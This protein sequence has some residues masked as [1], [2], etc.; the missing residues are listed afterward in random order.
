M[1][2]EGDSDMRRL[3]CKIARYAVIA[4]VVIGVIVS[5]PVAAQVTSGSISGTVSDATGAIIP[6]ASVTIRN[7]G[8]DLKR[9]IVTNASG[10]YLVADLPVGQYE[11]TVQQKGFA[12]VKKVGVNLTVG[13][14]LAENVSLTVGATTEVVEVQASAAQVETASSEVGTLVGER[15]MVDLPL[16]GRDY[17]QLLLLA[18]GMQPVTNNVQSS[19]GGRT[20]TFIVGGTRPEGQSILLDGTDVQ[21]Y[22]MHGSGLGALGTSLGVDSIAEFETLTSTYSAEFG[23]MGLAINMATKGGT[24]QI[25]G[26][27]YDYLRNSAFDARNY[28]DLPNG[29]PPFRRNQFGGSV[30]GPIKKDSTFF[31]IN[32]EGYRQYLGETV[33]GYVPDAAAHNGQLPCGTSICTYSLSSVTQQLLAIYPIGT[34]G[35][36]NF[37]ADTGSGT[38]RYTDVGNNPVNEN[39]LIGRLDRKLSAKDDFFLRVVRD[40]GTYA[41]PFPMYSRSG[42]VV[43]GE[44]EVDSNSDYY[45]TLQESRALTTNL[46]NVFRYSFTRTSI[47][48]TPGTLG[49]VLNDFPGRGVDA[50]VT[51]TGIGDIGSGQAIPIT[52]IQNKFPLDEQLYWT[53]GAH[54][55]RFGGMFTRLQSRLFLP[56]GY[57]GHWTFQSMQAML[58]NNA[59]SFSGF[60]NGADNSR[61]VFHEWNY[62]V[63]VEDNWKVRHNLTLN[64]GLRYDPNS[65]P[66]PGDVGTLIDSIINPLTDTGY[67]PVSQVFQANETLR[68]YDPRIGLA[69]SPFGQKTVI[70]AGFGIFH[71]PVATWDYAGWYSNGPPLAGTLT[72][73]PA[74]FPTPFTVAGTASKPSQQVGTAYQIPHGTYV[75]QWNLR[76]ERDLGGGLIA[77]AGYIASRANHIMNM[78]NLNPPG[79]TLNSSGKPVFNGVLT[80]SNLSTIIGNT[81]VAMSNY[82][83]LQLALGGRVAHSLQM[84]LNYTWSKTLSNADATLSSEASA[85]GAYQVNPY[86]IWYD[87]GL[88]SYNMT[89][90]FTGNLL[91]DVPFKKNAWVSGYE[92]GV[93]PQLHSG[94]PYTVDIGYDFSRLVVATNSE[95]PDRVGNVYQAGTVAANPNCVAPASI[96]TQAHWYNPCAFMLPGATAANLHGVPGTLGDMARDEG[97]SPAFVGVDMSLQKVTKLT[98]RVKLQL[99]F[100]AFNFVNHTNFNVPSVSAFSSSSGGVPLGSAGAITSTIGTARQLQFGA[101]FVF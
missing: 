26:T 30:G 39:Y 23:G 87:Y 62:A 14:A 65:M 35:V 86:N 10:L 2:T 69:Y 54:D 21:G 16:N 41:D 81:P 58:Q 38:I 60:P 24:N 27:A 66:K 50:E 71:E 15:Q 80:N 75:M 22:Y 74:Y 17:N 57:T 31:F 52:A 90:V 11:I 36:G 85:G 70:H 55:V 20:S 100:E 13:A 5:Q 8:I 46:I 94:M 61:R 47:I 48:G 92:L 59:F 18:P 68:D 72:Q 6:G 42:Q 7:V 49:G 76:V 9:T 82:N 79:Y 25:H 33:S 32:Y 53:H 51:V 12:T 28:F 91:Y 93:L 67:T 99:R 98:E 34:P 45:V 40:S 88:S 101:K 4:S 19:T 3:L 96:H 29:P 95:R 1:K 77:S 44:T 89:N 73:M 83:S 84:Q 43:S 63:Y 64:M 37:G 78:A 97:T 56:L